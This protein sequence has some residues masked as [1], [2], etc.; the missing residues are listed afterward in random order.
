MSMTL[1][2]NPIVFLLGLAAFVLKRG[3]P[4][5]SPTKPSPPARP[6]GG[7]T[8]PPGAGLPPTVPSSFEP[9]PWPQV[10]PAGLPAFPGPGWVPDVPVGPGVAARASQLLPVL[11][12][13]GKGT[14]KIEN[15]AG[16]WIAYRAVAMGT[17]KGVVAYREASPGPQPVNTSYSGRSDGAA[18]H[19]AARHRED[20]RADQR[21]ANHS[22][23]LQGA[24]RHDRTAHAFVSRLPVCRRWKLGPGTKAAAV[25]FQRSQGLTPDGVIGPATWGALSTNN[26][27]ASSWYPWER[28]RFFRCRLTRTTHTRKRSIGGLA[29]TMA[30]TFLRRWEPPCSRSSPATSRARP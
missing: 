29:V 5:T 1:N 18:S 15:T 14:F 24:G 23:G 30:Q 26:R 28:S 4:T 13:A 25:A 16:R 20:T 11:W 19:R 10:V 6:P 17:K 9:A 8:L 21:G 27:E 12:K 3:S 22:P 2:L 7:T